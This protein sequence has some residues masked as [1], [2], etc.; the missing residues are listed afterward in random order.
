MN[1]GAEPPD[2]NPLPVGARGSEEAFA[3][4]GCIAIFDLTGECCRV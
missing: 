3:Y 4:H 2:P 1:M